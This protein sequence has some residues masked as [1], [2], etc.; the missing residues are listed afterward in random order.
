[1]GNRG[2]IW[3]IEEGYGG[4][5]KDMGNR[6]RIWGIELDPMKPSQ[7]YANHPARQYCQLDHGKA[8]R[9]CPRVSRSIKMAPREMSDFLWNNA[10]LPPCKKKLS[11]CQTD[12]DITVYLINY[13]RTCEVN[14]ARE[15]I[16]EHESNTNIPRLFERKII[17]KD[18]EKSY[19][20]ISFNRPHRVTALAYYIFAP[21]P[22]TQECENCKSKKAK[23]PGKDCLSLGRRIFKGACFNCFYSGLGAQC[24][25]RLGMYSL[26]MIE[27][28]LLTYFSFR[29]REER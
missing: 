4:S 9:H 29:Y 14:E 18:G 10:P 5:R 26:P 20:D 27:L 7:Q 13:I 19:T 15:I 23:G 1:M 25:L 8:D 21:K 17:W 16:D 2:K 3:G 24:S 11:T 6:G 12:E 22:L 28:D